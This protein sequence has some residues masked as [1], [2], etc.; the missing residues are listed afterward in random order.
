MTHVSLHEALGRAA[1]ACGLAALCGCGGNAVIELEGGPDDL[2]DLIDQDASPEQATSGSGDA[3][4][5]GAAGT[6]QCVSWNTADECPV[7]EIAAATLLGP[8]STGGSV[9][10]GPIPLAGQCCYLVEDGAGMCG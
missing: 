3:Y 4:C 6:M 7:G 8:C 5:A 2:V 10:C 1:L 9:T